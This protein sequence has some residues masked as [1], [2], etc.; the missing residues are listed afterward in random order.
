[1]SN[2]KIA[3]TF[4][5]SRVFVRQLWQAVQ[6]KGQAEGAHEANAFV[7]EGGPSAAETKPTITQQKICAQGESPSNP[8]TRIF[9]FI[10]IFIL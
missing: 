4:R 6:T 5:S 10:R 7:R 8:P 1:M 2:T 9:N 3:Q